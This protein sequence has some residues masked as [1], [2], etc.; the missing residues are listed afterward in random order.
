M[1]T[2]NKGH[3]KWKIL[4]SVFA[5]VLVV[6]ILCGAVITK[7]KSETQSTVTSISEVYLKEM[8]AQISSHFN[9]NLESQF[10]QIR[11]IAGALS[12]NDLKSEDL[13]KKFLVQAQADNHFA[14]IAFISS[15]GIAHS[16]DGVVPVMSKISDLDKLLSGSEQVISVN[17]TIWGSDT[18]LLGTSIASV[19]FG[20]EELTAIVIGIETSAIGERLGLDSNEETSS[21]SSIVTRTGDFVIK[22]AYSQ[23]ALSGSNLFTIYE[24]QAVFD[25]GYG[26]ASL[27]AEVNDGGYGIALL[28][29]GSHH[30]YI[31]YVPV[32]GTDWYIVTSMAYGTVNSQISHLSRLMI[33]VGVGIFSLILITIIT[34]F[35]LLRRSEKQSRKLLLAEKERAEAANRA[36]S[37]FLSQMSHEIRTPLNGIIGMTEVGRQYIKDADRMENC[38]DKITLSS[39]HL[40]SL[41]NDILDMSKIESG[42]IELHQEKFDLGQLLRVLTTVFYVQAKEKKIEYEIYL[43]G[44]LEEYLLGD[45]LRLNQI[46][47]NLLSNAMKFTP[48]QGQV[49]L[50][51]EEL[52]REES[53]L[54]IR[55]EVRDTGRGIAPE[56][57]DR[58][59]EAFTQENSGITRQYGGTGLGLPIT[60]SFA[61]MMGGS[62]TA[63]SEIGVGSTF[64]VDLPFGYAK[65][66]RAEDGDKCG[67]GEWILIMSQTAKT[68]KHFGDVL[69]RED[70]DAH[71][72]RTEE[73]ALRILQEATKNHKGY[74]LCFISWNFSKDM[75]LLFD[76]VQ[77]ASQNAAMK[78]I[79]FGYDQDE[80]DEVAALCGADTTVCRPAFH[81]DIVQLMLALTG[82]KKKRIKT[83]TPTVLDGTQVLVVE[84]N[85]IN[86]FIAIELLQNAGAIVTTAGN[87]QEAVDQF[88][89]S[90]EGFYDLVLMD[91]QMPVMDGYTATRAIRALPRSDA[92]SAII[93]AMT[94]NSFLED[95]QRCLDS[96]MD[97]HI[98]KPFV[99]QD[100]YS[101]YTDVLNRTDDKKRN[102]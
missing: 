44:K 73:E 85:E 72:A 32:Q 19:Q 60:K 53:V 39:T 99:M 87:G 55:F 16:P 27:R 18:I 9:T 77:K 4:S 74:E 81:T 59:F 20:D 46:L 52:R 58:I 37:N 70:F 17:E 82:Q 26:L 47:T 83:E 62:I 69:R 24:Q 56:N 96:G 78:M 64:Q 90:P 54:W 66:R 49:S 100:V 57:L 42:K 50:M 61:E 88:S 28:T 31:Y 25:E 15:E 13:L 89:A 51:V 101:A 79:V 80:I 68:E 65:E 38:L 7:I 92:K 2:Q 11:T 14:H 93:I 97:A 5:L 94:A 95:I 23:V 102:R 22:S 86:L 34:F 98:A 10:S 67:N 76:K 29:V 8:A 75:K 43:L 48:E 33:V 21:H 40:L 45:A 3:T 41:I 91:I 63:S 30:E 6:A 36:K 12:E 71:S 1:S 84:D 35:L